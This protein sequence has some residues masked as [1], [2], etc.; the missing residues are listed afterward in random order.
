ML[1]KFSSFY[2]YLQDWKF[3]LRVTV[4]PICCSTSEFATWSRIL[5][6]SHKMSQ[7]ARACQEV[8]GVSNDSSVGCKSCSQ[9]R[10]PAGSIW[11]LN[12]VCFTLNRAR[13]LG[14]MMSRDQRGTGGGQGS[15]KSSL[16]L[17]KVRRPVVVVQ[18]L[19]HVR[20]VVTPWTVAHQASLSITNSGGLLKLMA[21]ESVMPSNHLILCCLLLLLPSIFPS[22]R[23]FSSKLALCISWPNNWSFS[24]SISPSS[25]YSGFKIT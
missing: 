12:E 11:G 21:I 7:V 8:S 13:R 2:L 23:V 5:Y 20:L 24:F 17:L 19:S 14:L 6:N 22:I 15:G 16:P 25:K 9:E 10:Q 4:A 3:T 18:L 1:E